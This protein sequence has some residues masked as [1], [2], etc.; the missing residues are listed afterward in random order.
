[1][2]RDLAIIVACVVYLVGW[3]VLT[4]ATP[5]VVSEP[6]S[7]FDSDADGDIDLRDFAV[8]QNTYELDNFAVFLYGFTGP[9]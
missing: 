3:A 8:F 7:P 1:M 4:V 5:T 6:E 9:R 2:K